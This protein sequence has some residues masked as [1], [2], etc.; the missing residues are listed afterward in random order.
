VRWAAVLA[1]MGLIFYLSA[2]PRLP[3]VI[4]PVLPQIQDIIGHFTVYAVLAVLLRWALQGAGIRHPMLWALA[5]TVLYGVT[6][7][8][9]QSFVPNRHPDVFDLATDLAGAV[10]A[11]WIVRRLGARRGRATNAAATPATPDHP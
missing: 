11:L 2:Q 8:F 10:A 1:W 7:E 9:H 4:P 3:R 6:D 5:A